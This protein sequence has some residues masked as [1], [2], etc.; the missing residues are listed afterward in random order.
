M[1]A[2]IV[3]RRFPESVG[4]A[5]GG[6]MG[7]A[8]APK[9][10]SPQEEEK[11]EKK[12]AFRARKSG[13]GGGTVTY[14]DASGDRQTGVTAED[15]YWASMR[16]YYRQI[17]RSQA[18]AAD[19]QA[20]SAAARAREQADEQRA[21]LSANYKDTNRQLYRDYMERQRLLPQ[22]LAAR[23]Y[24]GGLTESARVRLGNSYGE[25]L[26]ANERARIGREAEIGAALAQREYEA[27]AAAAE[28]GRQA[29]LEQ[30]GNLAGLRT[31]QH[32]QQRD[33]LEDRAAL[34]AQAGDFSGYLDLGY[35]M[36]EIE[37]LTKIWRKQHPRLARAQGKTIPY[38][39][40]AADR[41]VDYLAEELS[42]GNLDAAEAE[43]LWK[44]LRGEG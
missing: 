32:Q 6:A 13:G 31:A 5:M 3:T 9:P 15:P 7:A 18:D 43:R 27:R 1:A 14:V 42:A 41:A 39:S 30:Y 17:Y 24:T 33:E 4:G 2:E 8:F 20:E 28:A 29:L 21:A 34:L 11:E 23:G 16:D 40:R 36:E 19:A 12:T 44:L 26:A 25:S 22:Q 10:V 37:Y 38:T 35:T